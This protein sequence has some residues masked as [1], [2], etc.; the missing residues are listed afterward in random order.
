MFERQRTAQMSMC[1]P[2]A[3]AIVQLSP[4]QTSPYE[5]TLGLQLVVSTNTDIHRHT[6][7]LSRQTQCESIGATMICGEG[8]S[9]NTSE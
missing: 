6:H 3:R 1:P 4:D 5:E 8:D 7:A 2:T 9:H